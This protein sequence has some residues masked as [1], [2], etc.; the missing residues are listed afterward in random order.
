LPVSKSRD[1]IASVVRDARDAAFRVWRDPAAVATLILLSAPWVALTIIRENLN[2]LDN[3][4]KMTGVVLVFWFMSRSGATPLP[5]I[6]QPRIESLFAF[7]L[8][9]LWVLWRV[10]ICGQLFFFLP[11][12]FKCYQNWEI[13]I[14]P[15]VV[16]QVIFPI[17]VLSLA[18]YR[19]RAQGLDLNRRAWWICSPI[20]LAF[21]GYGIYSHYAEPL[22]YVQN[23]WE[24]FWGAG[25]PEEVLFRA[26]LLTRLEAWWRNPAWALYGASA[27]FGLTHLPINY[28]VFTSRDWR[29]AWLTL[30]TFQMGF[31]AVF[32]FAYQRTRNVL[33]I[34]VMHALLDSL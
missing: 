34:A 11:S 14:L 9:V 12:D 30:L 2:P 5:E 33:P 17:L 21:V 23:I 8:I 32:A 24:F 31:G 16:E 3:F 15:K 6:R 13:E 7:A 18:G 19:W 22:K 29:E 20:L 1:Y 4:V 26:I 27:I 28:L 25:L 10:G